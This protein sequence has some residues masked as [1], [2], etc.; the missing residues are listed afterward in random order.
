MGRSVQRGGNDGRETPGHVVFGESSLNFP[1]GFGKARIV[2]QARQG[3]AQAL[4]RDFAGAQVEAR[5]GLA[6]AVHGQQLIHVRA[7]AENRFAL[8]QRLMRGGAATVA[9]DQRGEGGGLATREEG[10]G[11]NLRRG[12]GKPFSSRCGDQAGDVLGLTGGNDLRQDVY[13]AG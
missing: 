1:G 3:L 6:D 11:V 2:Q 7:D 9:D 10:V 4:G 13:L 8:R 5:T 12:R